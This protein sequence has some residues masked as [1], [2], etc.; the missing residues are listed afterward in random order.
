MKGKHVLEGKKHIQRGIYP[1]RVRKSET[2]KRNFGRDCKM[3]KV[4]DGVLFYSFKGN[5]LRVVTEKE[6]KD[7]LQSIHA[8]PVGGHLGI[9]RT[10]IS[11]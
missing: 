6:N 10:L 3:F 1:K 2:K 7:I 9:N 8:Q 5:D 11:Y 4:K